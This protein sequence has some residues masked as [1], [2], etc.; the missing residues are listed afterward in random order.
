MGLCLT[1]MVFVP[2]C[3]G[4]SPGWVSVDNQTYDTVYLS[5]VGDSNAIVLVPKRMIGQVQVPMVGQGVPALEALQVSFPG[6]IVLPET[7]FRGFDGQ[8]GQPVSLV[9]VSPQNVTIQYDEPSAASSP[10]T[11]NPS[12]TGSAGSEGIYGG[13]MGY[14]TG[15]GSPNPLNRIPSPGATRD[16]A[17]D[18]GNPAKPLEPA[19]KG[20]LLP[21]NAGAK[22]RIV[23]ADSRYK[24]L[25]APAPIRSQPAEIAKAATV[26]AAIEPPEEKKGSWRSLITW[27]IVCVALVGFVA[28][29]RLSSR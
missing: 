28:W 14:G 16:E 7:E 11:N 15:Y 18:R 20:L 3:W 25:E 10:A 6:G 13:G 19:K 2:F 22:V 1:A 23:A 17:R 4:T 26:A 5:R 24:L 29:K 9:I 27:I 8:Y 12:P 21:Q